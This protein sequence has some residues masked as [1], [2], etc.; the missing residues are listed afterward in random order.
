VGDLHIAEIRPGRLQEISDLTKPIT[1]I[2]DYRTLL[3]NKSIDAVFISTTPEPTHYPI[4]KESLLAGKH[5][6]LEKPIALELA[7]ADELI[8][9][10]RSEN[11][12]FTI[13]CSTPSSPTSNGRS[14]MAASA[15]PSLR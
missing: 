10:A 8:A 9:L 15:N 4:A 12:L 7:E 1:A 11:L 6:F 3:N 2:T 13:G 5:V 14:T